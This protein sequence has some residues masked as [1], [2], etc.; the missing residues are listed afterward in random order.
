MDNRECIAEAGDIPLLILL[1]YS[2]DPKA[3]ENTVTALLN[4]S[5]YERNKAKIMQSGALQPIINVLRNGCSME[6][7]EN[8]VAMLFNLSYVDE[9]SFFFNSLR[10]HACKLPLNGATIERAKGS[11]MQTTAKQCSYSGWT[12]QQQA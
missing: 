12:P 7:R 4:L 11:C 3:Q 9:Y 6:A 8:V 1:L 10:D 2:Q 5:I